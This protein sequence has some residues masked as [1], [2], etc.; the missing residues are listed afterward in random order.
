MQRKLSDQ[1]LDKIAENLL[2]DFALDDETIDEIAAS[3]QLLWNVKRRIAAEKAEQKKSWFNVFRPQI[4]AFGAA[5]ILLCGI[6]AFL[7]LNPHDVSD[8]TIA[9]QTF[10]QNP[11][12]EVN[13]TTENFSPSE[14]NVDLNDA[15][16]LPKRK[17][18]AAK[19]SLK[20]AVPKIKFEKQSIKTPAKQLNIVSTAKI[21]P[22]TAAVTETKTDFIALSYAAN[23]DSGQIV[24]V[25]VPG[26]MLIALGLKTNVEKPSELVNAEVLIGD[27]GAAR[28]I[29]FIH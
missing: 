7:F 20:N 29:R 23:T 22:E 14:T 13:K 1:Q 2:R 4:L 25:K 24:R 17:F 3:P 28:A 12:S 9:Q 18:A 26:S 8:A 27:D 16:I 6:P 11:P 10:I 21:A 15:R 5:A 19:V